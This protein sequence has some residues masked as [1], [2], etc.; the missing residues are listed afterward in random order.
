MD[1]CYAGC[2]W[3]ESKFML[4]IREVP[5]R[6]IHPYILSLSHS[7]TRAHSLKP[8]PQPNPSGKRERIFKCHHR[9]RGPTEPSRRM[10]NTGISPPNNKTPSGRLA[11]TIPFYVI[12]VVVV[13]DIAVV[14]T[15][16]PSLHFHFL[17]PNPPPTHPQ[18]AA[19]QF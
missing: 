7:Y 14:S 18:L 1:V 4:R 5:H 17:P 8:T 2:L 12:V 11:K 10:V 16:L 9:A 13:A 15:T 19:S 3:C 6:H